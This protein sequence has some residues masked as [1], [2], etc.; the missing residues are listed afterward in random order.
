MLKGIQMAISFIAMWLKNII[1]ICE[2]INIIFFAKFT[3]ARVEKLASGKL[4]GKMYYASQASLKANVY[5]I[6]HAI[7]I[8]LQQL[9][10]FFL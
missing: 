2:Y 6:F 4:L 9:S 8:S 10:L 7:E 3:F 1:L 5:R